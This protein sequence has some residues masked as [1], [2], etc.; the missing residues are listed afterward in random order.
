MQGTPPTASLPDDD[1]LY[2]AVYDEMRRLARAH[3]RSG[4]ERAT[5]NTTELVH[6]AFLK[7]AGRDGSWENRAHFFGSASRAMRQVLVDFARR[8][9][10]LKRGGPMSGELVAAGEAKLEIEFDRLLDL[11]L[12]LRQLDTVDRR[13]GRVVELRFFGGVAEADIARMLGVS[14]RTIERD[15]L[16][17]RLFLRKELNERRQH[18]DR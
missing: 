16:K 13:L 11:D 8:R 2:A 4:A 15:W 3:L 7:L 5:L 14:V 10:A 18:Q 1:A 6:E 17:A 12:A 9:Q